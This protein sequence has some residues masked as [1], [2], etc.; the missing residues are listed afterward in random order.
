M[1]LHIPSHCTTS[2]YVMAQGLIGYTSNG[3]HPYGIMRQTFRLQL[4]SLIKTNLIKARSTYSKTYSHREKTWLCYGIA[5]KTD[6]TGNFAYWWPWELSENKGKR[7]RERVRDRQ[8]GRRRERGREGERESDALGEG[9]LSTADAPD[10]ASPKRPP[11]RNSHHRCRW[12]TSRCLK[13]D[14]RR[15]QRWWLW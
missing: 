8:A 14:L 7:E 4:P 6:W 9:P 3:E 12:R 5:G 1:P 10:A 2:E 11:T 15:W 13:V